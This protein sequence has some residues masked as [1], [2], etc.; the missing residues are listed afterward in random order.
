MMVKNNEWGDE[1]LLAD[2]QLLQ[3]FSYNLRNGN[4]QIMHV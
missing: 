4:L 3:E 1:K 2:I